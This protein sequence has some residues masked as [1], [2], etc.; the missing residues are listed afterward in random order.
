MIIHCPI[1]GPRGSGEFAYNGDATVS[2]DLLT[3]DVS[4]AHAA[5]HDRKNP[6]GEH[7]EYWQHVGGCRAILRVDRNTV[8]HKISR[9]ELAGPF[10]GKKG[11]TA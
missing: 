5:V 8:T 1:C 9:V 11:E 4:K 3:E 7:S 10:A 6:R 2:R